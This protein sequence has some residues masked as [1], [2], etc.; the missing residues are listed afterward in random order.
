VSNGSARALFRSPTAS[1]Q[2]RPGLFLVDAS[3]LHV[4][5][6]SR[7]REHIHHVKASVRYTRVRISTHAIT[8]EWAREPENTLVERMWDHARGQRSPICERQGRLFV[9][10]VHTWRTEISPQNFWRRTEGRAIKDDN[11]ERRRR[12]EPNSRAR[13]GGGG[14]KIP[15]SLR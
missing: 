4:R 10:F 14:N 3:F 8:A 1:N 2:A 9:V 6:L 5:L 13:S 15:P 11:A 12:E 7:A